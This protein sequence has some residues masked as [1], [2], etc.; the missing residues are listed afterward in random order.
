M[1]VGVD[2]A[3]ERQENLQKSYDVARRLG[4]AD[5]LS[6]GR[7]YVR[8]ATMM[9]VCRKQDKERWFVLFSDI[10]IYSSMSG[11][12]TK[13]LRLDRT[14]IVDAPEPPFAFTIRSEQ[15]SFVV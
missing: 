7:F 14:V 15:K 9:K 6:E 12:D 4:M 3:I 5:L 11:L 1:V 8:D 13:V 2:G 10:L